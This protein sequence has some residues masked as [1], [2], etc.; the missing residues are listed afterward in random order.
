MKLNICLI[1]IFAGILVFAKSGFSQLGKPENEEFKA[2]PL[3]SQIIS[4]QP[5]TRIVLWEE[6]NIKDTDAIQ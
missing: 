4:V 6:L 3:K 1:V 5:M 2:V